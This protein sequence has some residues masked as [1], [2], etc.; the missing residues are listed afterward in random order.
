MSN[1]TPEDGTVRAFN[2]MEEALRAVADDLTVSEEFRENQEK[3]RKRLRNFFIAF[4]VVVAIF[5]AVGVKFYVDLHDSLVTN[6]ENNNEAR[7]RNG[8]RWE[9]VSDLFESTPNPTPEQVK[10][11]SDFR[12][13]NEK[14]DAPRD[15]DNLGKKYQLPPR[16]EIPTPTE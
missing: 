6:C 3:A 12:A 8:E 1:E 2:S 9:F 14:L 7:Q 4:C 5:G 10:F 15:C 16:P 11:F 13:W